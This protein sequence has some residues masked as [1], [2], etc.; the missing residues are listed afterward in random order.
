MKTKL[1]PILLLLLFFSSKEELYS[2]TF[3]AQSATVITQ[4]PDSCSAIQVDVLTWLGCINFQ[5]GA[6]SFTVNGSTI[7][8]EVHY[9]S[10]PIC[11]GAISQPLFNVMLNNIPAGN[12]TIDAE[13]YLDNVLQNSV[14]GSITVASCSTT[15]FT[16]NIE[17]TITI[18][19]NPASDYI[20]INGLSNMVNYEVLD[21]SGKI[22][23]NGKNNT[24]RISELNTGLY[25]L[26]IKNGRSS[27]LQKF[28]KR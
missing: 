6:S 4:S 1:L 13:A 20:K 23:L 3:R 25:F 18:S 14:P 24:I 19:P 7:T 27:T 8:I 15:G 10:S 28:V 12:Y 22:L 2:Q 17:E 9:T 11:A 5:K 26:K 16:E 21:I